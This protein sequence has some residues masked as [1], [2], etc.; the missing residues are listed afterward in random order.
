MEMRTIH[1]FPLR[2]DI[3]SVGCIFAEMIMRRQLFPGR[4]AAMQIKMIVCYLG[5]PEQDVNF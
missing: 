2:V 5:T 4:D 1:N 3:W